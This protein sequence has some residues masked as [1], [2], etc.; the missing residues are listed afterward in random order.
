MARRWG[1][2]L[3]TFRPRIL[4]ACCPLCSLACARP[5]R[6][7]GDTVGDLHRRQHSEQTEITPCYVILPTIYYAA[8][9]RWAALCCPF[10]LSCGP[11]PAA[12]VGPPRAHSVRA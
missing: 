10:F 11:Q 4:P 1:L 12:A 5:S 9:G 6:A 8:A 3:Y 7:R 2:A